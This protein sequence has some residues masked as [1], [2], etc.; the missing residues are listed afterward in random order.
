MTTNQSRREDAMTALVACYGKEAGVKAEP[1]TALVDL[2][3]NILHLAEHEKWDLDFDDALR[4]ARMHQQEE[5]EEDQ[6]TRCRHCGTA[7]HD[8]SG[9]CAECYARN[10]S[11][12]GG[13]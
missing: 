8:G 5:A 11:T 6:I 7:T 12:A 1:Q 3:T 4:L 2:L 10:Y 13:Q 9:V